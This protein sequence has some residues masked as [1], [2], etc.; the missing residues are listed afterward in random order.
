MI[1]PNGVSLIGRLLHRLNLKFP[2]LFLILGALTLLDIVVPDV[3]PFL[4]EIGL[5][6]LTLLFG[7]WKDRK[8]PGDPGADT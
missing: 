2:T 8:S 1:K 6:V 7:M 4:D 3:I 5:A